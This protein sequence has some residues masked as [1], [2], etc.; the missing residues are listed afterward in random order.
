MISHIQVPLCLQM[1]ESL[2]NNANS[3][4]INHFCQCSKAH[5][6]VLENSMTKSIFRMKDTQGYPYFEEELSLTYSASL[7]IGRRDSDLQN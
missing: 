6:P 1:T 7:N 4:A 3:T 5:W 2:K